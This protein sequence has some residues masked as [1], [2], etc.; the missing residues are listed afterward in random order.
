MIL[1]VGD[2]IS[3]MDLSAGRRWSARPD[4]CRSWGRSVLRRSGRKRLRV[5]G[6][7]TV[8]PQDRAGVFLRLKTDAIRAIFRRLDKGICAQCTARVFLSARARSSGDPLS[9]TNPGSEVAVGRRV[10]WRLLRMIAGLRLVIPVGDHQQLVGLVA[11]R[12]PGVT[13]SRR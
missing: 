10:R 5:C 13:S 12:G 6:A 7:L 11:Q 9:G 1:I 2:G 4:G 8:H 3:Y